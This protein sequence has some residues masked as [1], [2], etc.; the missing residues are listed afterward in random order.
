MPQRPRTGMLQSQDASYCKI[1]F[2]PL[3]GSLVG[4]DDP[5]S[6]PLAGSKGTS[7]FP[8]PWGLQAS[9]APQQTPN[10]RQNDSCG[11]LGRDVTLLS[12]FAG[13]RDATAH[14]CRK[15][16]DPKEPAKA[17]SGRTDAGLVG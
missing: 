8:V 2:G 12:F 17:V 3:G 15:I 10:W 1:I 5:S 7:V 9:P 6:R 13:S 14:G 16:A 11:A 4:P